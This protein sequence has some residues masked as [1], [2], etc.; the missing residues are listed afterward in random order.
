MSHRFQ[1]LKIRMITTRKL[2]LEEL[3][4]YKVDTYIGQSTNLVSQLDH[5]HRRNPEM[6]SNPDLKPPK[7]LT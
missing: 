4:Q 1:L 3:R 2:D 6:F 5:T 7:S